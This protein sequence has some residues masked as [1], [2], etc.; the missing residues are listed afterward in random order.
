MSVRRASLLISVLLASALTIS[1]V[2]A[3]SM[4][5]FDL[6]S[7]IFM[8]KQILEVEVIETRKTD[9]ITVLNLNV[10]KN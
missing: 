1:G 7:L 5:S 8:S 6:D 4:F 10:L 2:G 3:K 9:W